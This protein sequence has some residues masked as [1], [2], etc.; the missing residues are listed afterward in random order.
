DFLRRARE[1]TDAFVIEVLSAEEEARYGYL[2]AANSTTLRDGAVLE[3]GGGS[4]QLIEV[5]DRRPGALCSFELGA[6]W[7]TER[8][9]SD[10]GP[11]AKSDLR[12]LRKHVGSALSELEWLRS[13][14][15]LV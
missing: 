3:L 12:K 2:A 10:G 5:R 6:V 11:T 9:L 14:A 13:S 7:L 1:T 4:L 15:A 8:F